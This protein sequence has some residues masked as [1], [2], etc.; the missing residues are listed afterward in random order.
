MPIRTIRRKLKEIDRN[1]RRV[2]RT[3]ADRIVGGAFVA[4]LL[5]APLVVLK[6][7]SWVVKRSTDTLAQVAVFKGL[8]GDEIVAKRYGDAK[9]KT[10]AYPPSTIPLAEVRQ[11]Q[12]RAWFGWPLAT[13][14]EIL[15]PRYE[16]KLL[17]ACPPSR[18]P[19]VRAAVE[20]ELET[21]RRAVR[22]AA[23][24]ETIH[25]GGWIFSI[26][27]WWVLITAVVWLVLLPVRVGREVHR[28]TRN[29]VRQ[30]RVDRCHCP[31]CGYDGRG[32]ITTGRCPECGGDLYERPDW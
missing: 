32:S 16:V 19:E 20:R 14:D 8:E 4:S 6:M 21:D 17:P 25:F 26:G 7:E 31:N 24:G 9:A 10:P 29:A 1:S 11:L 15:A 13:R 12:D 18:E 22:P 2:K 23:S 30:G 28:I 3:W 5:F 27:A